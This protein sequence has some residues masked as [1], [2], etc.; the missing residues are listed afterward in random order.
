MVGC[1]LNTATMVSSSSNQME[2]NLT[3]R[4]RIKKNSQQNSK[5]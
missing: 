3:G 5:T 1:D 4:M 2:S